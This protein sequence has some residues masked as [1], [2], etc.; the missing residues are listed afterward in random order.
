MILEQKKGP[1]SE[2]AS[3]RVGAVDGRG[4]VH[5][6]I[7][8]P[9]SQPIEYINSVAQTDVLIETEIALR[10]IKLIRRVY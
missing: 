7:Q 1:F 2:G 8:I 9:K 6:G 3:F 5:I 4:Y 10:N